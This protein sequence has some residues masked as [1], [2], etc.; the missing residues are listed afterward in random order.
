VAGKSPADQVA[1]AKGLLDS[2]AI[3]QSEF[4]SLKAKALS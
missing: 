4:E 1:Q 2:G 3:S